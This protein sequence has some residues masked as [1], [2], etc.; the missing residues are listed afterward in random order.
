MLLVPFNEML[1]VSVFAPFA[2]LSLNMLPPFKV[3]GFGSVKDV[4]A[5][6]NVAAFATTVVAILHLVLRYSLHSLYLH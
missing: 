5:K 4:P 6:F 3:T 1:P 2:L